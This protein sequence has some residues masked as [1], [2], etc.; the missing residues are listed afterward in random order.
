MPCADGVA[1][2]VRERFGE[3]LEDHPVQLGVRAANGELDVLARA[4]ARSRTARGSGPAIA[5]SGSVRIMI[6][7]SLSSSSVRRW[8]RGHRPRPAAS[9][10]GRRASAPAGAGPGWPRR[11]RRAGDRSSPP[12]PAPPL[13][14]RDRRPLA[15]PAR[16]SRLPAGLGTS[17]GSGSS[18]DPDGPGGPATGDAAVA[19]PLPSTAARP[20]ASSSSSAPTGSPLT[21]AARTALVARRRG[22]ARSGGN[23]P[24]SRTVAEDVLDGVRDRADVVEA[25]HPGRSLDGVDVAEQGVDRLGPGLTGFDRQQRRFHL[26]EAAYR[27]VAEDLDQLGVGFAHGG[28]SSGSKTRAG[29]SRRRAPLP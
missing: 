12:G 27:F 4:R 24:L 19:A 18:A 3:A 9:P 10:P 23:V 5:A 20:A 25:E 7:V 11:R 2:Q 6:A 29:R 22:A 17:A 13:F 16:R 21:A 1:Q 8:R 15:A 14:G 26:V 28:C